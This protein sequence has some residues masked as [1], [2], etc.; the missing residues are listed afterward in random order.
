VKLSAVARYF[1]GLICDD[2]YTAGSPFQVQFDLFDDTRRDGLTAERRI[3]SVAPEVNPPSRR[4]FVINEAGGQT[5]RWIVGDVA[6]D[7]FRSRP[8]RRK[9]ICHEAQGL[10]DLYTY[11]GAITGTPATSAYAAKAWIKGSKELEISS[12][13]YNV[14]DIYLARTETVPMVIRLGGKYYLTRTAYDTEGG[15]LALQTD[16]LVDPSVSVTLVTR[17]YQPVTDIWT[18][19]ETTI[20]GFLIRWQSH[21]RYFAQYSAKY[22]PG[23]A[24]LLVLKTDAPLLKQGD[25]VTVAGVGYTVLSTTDEGGHWSAHVRPA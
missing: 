25:L 23:D 22:E 3:V 5:H 13:L 12:G 10:A 18:T 17:N 1:D 20:P 11:M 8:I 2:A 14:W 16:E 9:W 6:T 19:T 4:V 7:Y 24:Q 21:F 15:F